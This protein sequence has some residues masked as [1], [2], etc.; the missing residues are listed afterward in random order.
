M[1]RVILFFCLL[2]LSTCSKDSNEDKSSVYV[3]PQSTNIAKT[4]TTPSTTQ[5][6]L[7][8]TAGEGGSVSTSGGTYNTGTSVSITATPN[9]G[10]GFLGWSNSSSDNPINISLNSDISI[11]ANF[12]QINYVIPESFNLN[13]T[14]ISPEIYYSVDLSWDPIED[15]YITGLNV[16]RG[17]NSDSLELY[18]TLA[19]GSTSFKDI[20]V[21][22]RM[23]YFYSISYL[24]DDYEH[25]KTQ[26]IGI[27]PF[28]P[29]NNE[30]PPECS[31]PCH[32][33]NFSQLF[34]N[35]NFE[36]IKHKFTIHEEPSNEARMY[37]SMFFG[38]INDSID[39]YYGIQTDVLKLGTSPPW[40][41]RGLIFSRWQTRDTLNYALADDGWGQ[42]AGYEGDF[43]GVRRSYEWTVGTYETEIKRDS[44]DNIGDWYSL[45]IRKL[46]ENN[47]Y[48]I[49]S[50][51]FEFSSL[52]E[53][54]KPFGTGFLEIFGNIPSKEIPNWHVSMDDISVD[55]YR[56]PSAINTIYVS[57]P[58]SFSNIYTTNNKNFHSIMGPNV[59]KITPGKY[60]NWRQ[61]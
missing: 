27:Y 32:I 7:T 48:Y 61:D 39:F 20:E 51:R 58:E 18:K 26:V 49:G 2:I 1:R 54:I 33:H 19:P 44:S 13:S 30:A 31:A 57:E 15:K 34:D 53:G 56:K 47:Q 43:I 17:Y 41:G 14:Y 24:Y 38:T 10:Y 59:K 36:S 42:S 46:P 9:S 40:G 25:D 16:Y 37:Y 23:E 12:E 22:I 11:T 29:L 28:E 35:Q 45:K 50:I 5:Y 3:N 8:V 21:S 52:S 4:T 60:F 55:E 6:T